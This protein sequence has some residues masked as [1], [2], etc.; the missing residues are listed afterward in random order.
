MAFVKILIILAVLLLLFFPLLPL[1]LKMRRFSTFRALRYDPPHNRLN[2][3]F[4]LLAVFE[5]VGLAIAYVAIFRLAKG[6]MGVSFIDRLLN[7]VPAVLEFNATVFSVLVLNIITLYTLVILKTIVKNLLNC[8]FG[9]KKPKKDKKV[10]KKKGE[11]AAKEDKSAK[12]EKKRGRIA[13]ILRSKRKKDEEEEERGEDA[14][15]PPAQDGKPQERLTTAK[16]EK[17]QKEHPILFRLY[18]KFWGLFF[19]K[20]DFTYARRYVFTAVTAIQFFIYLVEILYALVFFGMLLAVFFSVPNFLYS[21]LSF[22]TT[23]IYIYPFISILFLQELCNTFRSACKEPEE[24]EK[25]IKR[26]EKKKE[27]KK[28]IAL[29]KLRSKILRRYAKNH[30][31]LFNGLHVLLLPHR[32]RLDGLS[33]IGHANAVVDPFQLIGVTVAYHVNDIAYRLLVNVTLELR[34]FHEILKSAAGGVDRL[35]LTVHQNGVAVA[36]L[37]VADVHRKRLLDGLHVLVKAAEHAAC[38][39]TCTNCNDPLHIF[40]ISRSYEPTCIF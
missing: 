1:P 10:K 40:L 31:I 33:A 2:L 22:V 7:K 18:Q 23:K 34:H 37:T 3:S 17:F 28:K 29:N 35:D 12:K 9:F 15:N 26:E 21:A 4:V 6:L 39:F 16:N 27:E 11:E 13:R 19:E 32:F 20:P 24:T 14:A 30:S 8:L 5:F 25:V 36:R 38:Y